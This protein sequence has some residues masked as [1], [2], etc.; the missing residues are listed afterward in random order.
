VQDLEKPLSRNDV[1]PEKDDKGKNL[2][3]YISVLVF[4]LV[5]ANFAIAQEP[6]AAESAPGVVTFFSI[7][8]GSG[9]VGIIVWA[10]IFTM[11]PVG[12]IL[13]ISSVI[14]SV[15]SDGTKLLFSYKWL[16]ISPIFYF[17]IGAVGVMYGMHSAGN[18]LTS[19]TAA[20]GARIAYGISNTLS[21]SC[22]VLLGMFPFFFFI[23][24]CMIILHCKRA[25][26]CSE[27][28]SE[29]GGAS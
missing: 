20:Q 26:T 23:I 27:P 8:A 29:E 24:I 10:I 22:F 17:F 11:W 19:R 21:T 4:L 13:G 1:L 15:K 9:I 25:P 14:C 28:G 18:A 12:I 2:K 3:K 7:V 5:F 16:L 6:E